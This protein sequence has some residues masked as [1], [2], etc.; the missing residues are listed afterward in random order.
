MKTK[1]I[2]ITD[3]RFISYFLNWATAFHRLQRTEFKLFIFNNT[4]FSSQT[5]AVGLYK[6]FT[7]ANSHYIITN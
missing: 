2:Q 6:P 1:H 7:L 5:A 4:M 3:S